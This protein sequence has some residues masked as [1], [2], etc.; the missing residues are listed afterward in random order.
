MAKINDVDTTKL[1]ALLQTQHQSAAA[2][3][4]D[5]AELDS[6]LGAPDPAVFKSNAGGIVATINDLLEDAKTELEEA[7]KKEVTNKHNYEL[8]KLELD[9]AIAFANKQLDKA[10]KAKAEAAETKSVAEGDL[11]V[12]T[13][14]L[15]ETMKQL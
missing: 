6:M 12:T 3:E 5:D 2:A 13:K 14:G 4:S 11:S 15:A 8:L 10:K 7:R 9:D 1:S